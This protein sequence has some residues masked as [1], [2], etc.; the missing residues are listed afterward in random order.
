MFKLISMMTKIECLEEEYRAI[1]SEMLKEFAEEF[2]VDV[3]RGNV[4]ISM[5][6]QDSYWGFIKFYYIGDKF[7]I[8]VN[9]HNFEYNA[10]DPKVIQFYS[11]INKILSDETLNAKFLANF[12][13]LSEKGK[14]MVDDGTYCEVI[15]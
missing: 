7:L 10:L 5:R 15:K 4:D 11:L 9:T 13:E 6:I 1:F 8:R 2:S 14:K 3:T 12:K